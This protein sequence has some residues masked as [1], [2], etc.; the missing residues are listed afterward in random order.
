[1]SPS[2]EMFE[3]GK[4]YCQ[5]FENCGYWALAGGEMLS[6]SVSHKVAMNETSARVLVMMV[7]A[8]DDCANKITKTS[9]TPFRRHP[10]KNGGFLTTL[11]MYHNWPFDLETADAGRYESRASGTTRIIPKSRFSRLKVC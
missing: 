2:E 9:S 5:S 4:R 7:L 1:M 8:N 6:V 3:C 10:K 11:Q